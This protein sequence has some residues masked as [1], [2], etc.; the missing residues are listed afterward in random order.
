MRSS[1]IA[2]IAGVTTRTLRH[3]HSIGLL[4]EPPRSQNG[5]REYDAMDLTRVLHIKR[6]SSLGFSLA[7]IKEMIDEENAASDESSPNGSLNRQLIELTKLD[8]ELKLQIEDLKH[9]RKV[10]AQ[11]REEQLDPSL[12]VRFAKAVKRIYGSQYEALVAR[13]STENRAA[14]L[15]ASHFYDEES[16]QE[17]ERFVSKVEELDLLDSIRRV[18][19]KIGKLPA[20]A[21]EQKREALVK[22]VLNL[23]EPL[24]DCFDPQNWEAS[25]DGE[26]AI[27]ID[28][29]AQSSWN[30]AQLD[31]EKR[32]A[33]AIAQRVLQRQSDGL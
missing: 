10:I 25:E 15:L 28:S 5:Y 33:D 20:D 3:Y 16:L 12:P 6:L 9:R 7:Q 18:E 13:S 24:M 19:E 29:L 2:R 23:L 11:L 22:E 4:P 8:E 27:L 26:G 31:V 30:A 17:L 1:D 21:S 14:L 32:V